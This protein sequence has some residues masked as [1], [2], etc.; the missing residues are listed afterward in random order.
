[1]TAVASPAPARL[2]GS[3]VRARGR[4]WVLLPGGTDDLLLL[5]P[6]GGGDDDIA[7]VLP[8][9]EPVEDAT[10]AA[11]DPSDL[12][13]AASARLLRSALRLGFRSSGGPFR[14]L[15][16]LAVTPRS[17]QLVPLL[18]ALRMETARLLIAD[19]GGLGKTT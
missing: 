12:G 19:A 4:D 13:D 18:M 7:G 15:G 14:S 17:Y 2:P 16:G 11:P 9:L 6:L 10:F 3:L 1:M 5:R 8:E